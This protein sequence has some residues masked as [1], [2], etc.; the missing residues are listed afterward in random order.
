MMK[1]IVYL[2]MLLESADAL[3]WD[4]LGI[5]RPDMEKG[6]QGTTKATWEVDPEG[7]TEK[8]PPLEGREIRNL[9]L[10]RCGWVYLSCDW[11]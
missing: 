10:K 6:K 3:D 4:W 11:T 8:A 5:S 2:P 1:F 7:A 9:L